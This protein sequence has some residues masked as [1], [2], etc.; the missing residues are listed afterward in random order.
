[1]SKIQT[2]LTEI[3]TLSDQTPTP[4]AKL[5]AQLMSLTAELQEDACEITDA[6]LACLSQGLRHIALIGMAS[7]MMSSLTDL[8]LFALRPSPSARSR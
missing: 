4:K 3:Q 6:D 7:V 5:G 8:I 1:M 2:I